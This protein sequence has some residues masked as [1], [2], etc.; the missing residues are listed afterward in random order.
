M[1]GIDPLQQRWRQRGWIKSRIDLF[2]PQTLSTTDE[3]Q[4]FIE[5][6]RQNTMT[7][8]LSLK[9]CFAQDDAEE[10][11]IDLIPLWNAIYSDT[12]FRGS[13]LGRRCNRRNLLNRVG[14]IRANIVRANHA[15]THFS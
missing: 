9:F 12:V 14:R 7:T 8:R 3:V 15:G 10:E 1:D 11:V 6:W 4:E 5:Y 13:T 2:N